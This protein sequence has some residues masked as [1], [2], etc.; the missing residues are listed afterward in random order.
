MSKSFGSPHPLS[1]SETLK[2]R[3]MSILDAAKP[4]SGAYEVMKV[5]CLVTTAVN[6][7]HAMTDVFGYY[8][9]LH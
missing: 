8:K 4:S 5:T 6:V 1:I 2:S 7:R 3:K 9:V